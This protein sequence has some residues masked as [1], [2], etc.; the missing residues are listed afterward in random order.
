M[1]REDEGIFVHGRNFIINKNRAFTSS[2]APKVKK[3]RPVRGGG[4][5]GGGAQGGASKIKI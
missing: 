4:G 3:Q 1:A 5:G 2:A